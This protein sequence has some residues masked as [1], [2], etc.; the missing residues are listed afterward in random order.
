[1]NALTISKVM[2]VFFPL[3]LVV[4]IPLTQA[5]LA[6]EEQEEKKTSEQQEAPGGQGDNS[7]ADGTLTFTQQLQERATPQSR[8]E[9]N[10]AHEQTTS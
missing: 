10:T 4:S 3:T 9:V 6:Q 8:R 7:P 5:S 1:M 2:F